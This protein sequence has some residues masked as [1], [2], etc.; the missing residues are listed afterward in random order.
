[1]RLA[2]ASLDSGCWS[3]SIHCQW[4]LCGLTQAKSWAGSARPARQASRVRPPG[5]H[6]P[7]DHVSHASENEDPREPTCRR[8]TEL[9]IAKGE[10]GTV[11]ET[12]TIKVWV[13][14]DYVNA[15][16][17][18]HALR[19]DGLDVE[20]WSPVDMGRHPY[21]GYWDLEL[22]T[23]IQQLVVTVMGTVAAGG[24]VAAVKASVSKYRAHKPQ[25]LITIEGV[26]EE[27]GAEQDGTARQ[28]G[29]KPSTS[30]SKP[31]HPQAGAGT[32]AGRPPDH[33]ANRLRAPSTPAVDRDLGCGGAGRRTATG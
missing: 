3:R 19:G 33:H 29:S 26:D 14:G 10:T 17:L 30:T 23:D 7:V 21:R 16:D 6:E 18:A 27:P 9:F 25:A 28:E 31:A 5:S 8:F 13:K 15:R 24:L 32:N 11:N 22:S 2:V 20:H 1:M 4:R 12:Q